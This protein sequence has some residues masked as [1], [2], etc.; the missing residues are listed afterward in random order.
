MSL[1]STDCTT[2]NGVAI[3][4]LVSQMTYVLYSPSR[5]SSTR[6]RERS[7]WSEQCPYV[8]NAQGPT[9]TSCWPCRSGRQSRRRSGCRSCT[10]FPATQGQVPYI[11]NPQSTICRLD[12]V[13]KCTVENTLSVTRFTQYPNIRRHK[14]DPSNLSLYGLKEIQQIPNIIITLSSTDCTTS[15]GVAIRHLVSQMTYVLY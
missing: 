3:R 13:A 5:S 7:K 10:R 15:N 6:I 11:V 9:L 1:S 2:S 14:G 4:H 8:L 12:K